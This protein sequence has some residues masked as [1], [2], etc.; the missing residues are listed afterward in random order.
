MHIP[1]LLSDAAP[2]LNYPPEFRL[3]NVVSLAAFIAVVAAAYN[4]LPAP[5]RA[6]GT[7]ATLCIFGYAYTSSCVLRR[8]AAFG[9]RYNDTFGPLQLVGLIF[10]LCCLGAA[11]GIKS[12]CLPMYLTGF[13]CGLSIVY[14]DHSPHWQQFGVLFSSLQWARFSAVAKVAVGAIAATGTTVLL[15]HVEYAPMNFS[16]FGGRLCALAAGAFCNAAYVMHRA[17]WRP[18]Q[19]FQFGLHH[20][21]VGLVLMPVAALLQRWSGMPFVQG[22]SIRCV[23]RYSS[24]FS[25]SQDCSLAL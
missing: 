2:P 25:T 8:D 12:R 21:V 11:D 5:A 1:K 13:I 6:Y 15:L 17:H 18:L 14:A 7:V 4:A 16:V 10:A 3:S 20:Y 24:C 22:L 19:D 23:Y 9:T